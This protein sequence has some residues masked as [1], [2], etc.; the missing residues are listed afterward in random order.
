MSRQSFG[1]S[2]TTCTIARQSSYFALQFLVRI[3]PIEKTFSNQ[4]IKAW[5]VYLVC[6]KSLIEDLSNIFFQANSWFSGEQ[7]E[8]WE[9]WP[10]SCKKTN[11]IDLWIARLV[12]ELHYCLH[13]IM[14]CSWALLDMGW[15]VFCFTLG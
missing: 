14:D 6:I 11:W 9:Y 4:I 15:M 1:F 2:R 5:L 3:P 7:K 12:M 13:S 8:P 10:N